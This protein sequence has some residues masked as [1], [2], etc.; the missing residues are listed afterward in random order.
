M[1]A[2]RLARGI[3][4]AVLFAVAVALVLPRIEM[5]PS[6]AGYAL[7]LELAPRWLLL[8]PLF[9]CVLLPV[10]GVFRLGLLLLAAAAV[11]CLLDWRWAGCG[12]PAG[13]MRDLKVG[14]FNMGGGPV[15][16]GEVLLW[17]QEEALDILLLQEARPSD[18][19]RAA[20]RLG[21]K[22]VCRRGLCAV[23]QHG[24]ELGVVK[25]RRWSTY[26]AVF[27]LCRDAHCW[28][29]INLHLDTPRNAIDALLGEGGM[30]KVRQHLEAR[31][32]ESLLASLITDDVDAVIAGDF[33]MTRDS[34]LYRRYWSQWNNAFDAAGCGF[35]ATKESRLL[36]VR[37]D[38]ILYGKRWQAVSARRVASL[39][40]DHRPVIA[41]LKWRRSVPAP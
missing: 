34:H 7:L 36:A 23:S 4:A 35:G 15:V 41:S 40:G 39:G 30:Q 16:P 12:V 8:I 37:I 29:L 13:E 19:A 3:A 32:M 28:P 5:P 11:P 33:N 24:L 18:L 6:L 27:E 21:L 1:N 14:T 20:E 26:A 17:Y 22:V 25:D 10:G 38:H 31:E 2:Q 9:G